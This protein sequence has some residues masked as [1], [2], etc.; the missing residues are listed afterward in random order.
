[1]TGNYAFT[2]AIL[3]SAVTVLFLLGLA[4]F[5]W[6]RRRMPGA[7]PFAIASLFGI[8]WA[9]GSVMEYAAVG[10]TTKIFWVKFQACWQLPL[11]TSIICFC[12]EYAWPGRWLTRRNIVLFSLP[13]VVLLGLILTD[14]LHHWIY[15][16]FAFLGSVQPQPGPLGWFATAGG[17]AVSEAFYLIILGW[18]FLHSPQHRWPVAFMLVGQFGGRLFFLAERINLLHSI[19][20]IDLLGMG[21]E[22][23]MYTIALFGFQ[24]LDPIPQA[25]RAAIRQLHSGMLVLD[26]QGRVVSL[27]P[28]AERILHA[29]SRHVKGKPI[30][31]LLPAYPEGPLADLDETEIE[32]SLV[33][34]DSSVRTPSTGQEVRHYKLSISQLKDFRGLEIGRLLML[35]DV[36]GIKRAEVQLIE[37]QRALAAL[38][39]RGFLAHELHDSVGQILGFATLK[40]GAARKL[41]ADG[42]LEN[43]DDQ[44]AHLE[45]VMADAHADVREYILNLRTAPTREKPFF[46][47]LRDYLDGFHQNYGIQV[48]VSLSPGVDEDVFTSDAQIQL[49]RILQEALS[50]ARKHAA[51]NKVNISLGMEAGRLHML[52]QDNGKGFD[53]LQAVGVGSGH[54]G[55]GF[56]RE[57]AESLGGSLRVHSALGEGTCVEVEVPVRDDVVKEDTEM[58]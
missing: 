35:H 39:E 23:L 3:P 17:L 26:P 37:Q 4:V 9:A 18:L 54:F 53:P 30:Q 15:R 5:T 56:M 27:N 11:V 7:L 50:N 21:S 33:G 12:L 24:I 49:F 20:P 47:A 29:P 31:E 22:F 52:V 2:P 55:L 14:N 25:H 40:L 51:T 28:A 46:T 57:R 45:N 38:H 19:L 16:S 34:D 41:I 58:R 1:M 10:W 13:S 36:T 48:D 42:R 32:F 44:L 6:H 8:L 43:A